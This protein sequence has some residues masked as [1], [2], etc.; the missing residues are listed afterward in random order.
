M[1][2]HSIPSLLG[3][4]AVL[5]AALVVA[6]A[7]GVATDS[8]TAQ[9]QTP[10]DPNLIN[11]TTPLQLYAVRYDETGDGRPDGLSTDV[12]TAA[13]LPTPLTESS[14]ACADGRRRVRRLR[15]HG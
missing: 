7:F 4:A 9:A 1:K 6:V 3:I 8:P 14:R 15:V 13:L 10:D 5:I 2:S 11:I 12:A